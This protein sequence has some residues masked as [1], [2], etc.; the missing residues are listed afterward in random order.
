[1]GLEYRQDNTANQ[2]D[3]AFGD[4]ILRGFDYERRIS[5]T[6][7]NFNTKLGKVLVQ[8]GARL[9][10]FN[11]D[12]TFMKGSDK[13]GYNYS[14]F[15]LYPSV[16]LTYNPNRVHQYQLSYSRRVD[17]PSIQQLNP[18]REWSTPQI[19]SVGNPALDPQ[20]THSFEANYTF[21]FRK[22]NVAFSGFYRRVNDDITRVLSV[23]PLDANKVTL[24]YL[25]ADSNNRYG[26]ELSSFY[27]PTNWWMINSSTEWYRQNQNGVANGDQL[28]VTNNVFNAR[29]SH[30]F[31]V[32]KNLRVQLFGMYR[33][34]GR[35]IQFNREHMWMVNTG[36]SYNVLKGQG[37]ISLRFN[38]IFQG[39]RFKY[40]SNNPFHKTDSSIGKVEPLI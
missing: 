18:I 13:Q 23:D 14:R 29:M 30:S 7:L 36:A 27:R 21:N 24:S 8:A 34:G 33:G 12:G 39:M 4:M 37:T 9:E 6:Y 38:D 28:E 31:V 2:N 1:M 22:G 35:S 19:N 11:A 16:F 40:D 17:R 20:F 5:S 25:N 3:N 32:S 26:L 10:Q 15:N